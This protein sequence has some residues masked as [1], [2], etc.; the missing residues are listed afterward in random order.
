M[1]IHKQNNYHGKTYTMEDLEPNTQYI[2]SVIAIDEHGNRKSSM[3]IKIVTK[4]RTYLYKEGEEYTEL[5]GGWIRG[6]YNIGTF[7]KASDHL[8]LQASFPG[9]TNKY[10]ITC[11]TTN[12]IDVTGFK[13]IVYK[14]KIDNMILYPD[15][16]W[17]AWSGVGICKPR[18]VDYNNASGIAITPFARMESDISKQIITIK[19]DITNINEHVYPTAYF[20]RYTID[21]Y[22]GNL[23]IYEVWLEE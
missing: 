9:T 22:E 1:E 21:N 4:A 23:N 14:I 20:A 19:T 7:T 6:N 11:E 17:Y 12:S 15:E 18:F 8:N 5:T 16:G 10:W 3:P 2:V 13:K